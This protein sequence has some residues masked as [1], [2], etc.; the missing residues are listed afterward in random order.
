VNKTFVSKTNSAA[1]CYLR[2]LYRKIQH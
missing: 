1:S 2:F